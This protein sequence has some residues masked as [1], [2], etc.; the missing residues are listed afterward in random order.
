MSPKASKPDAP[1][2]A[3]ARV[4]PELFAF[5]AFRLDLRASQ[6]FHGTT[7][8]P[9]RPKTWAVLVYLAARAGM[10]VSKDDL[11]GAVWPDVAVTPDTLNKSIGEL[12]SALGD[13]SRTPRF[14]ET[15]HRRGFR[16]I[17]P[18]TQE[19][20]R[21]PPPIEIASG[22]QPSA[23]DLR[24]TTSECFVGR[25]AE[26]RHLTDRFAAAHA[27]DRQVVFVTGPAGVG[28]TAL[29][30]AF[31]ASRAVG[32][33]GLPV[34]IG[35]AGCI[36]QH[37]PQ[38]PYMPVLEALQRLVRPPN[39]ERMIALMRRAAP[40]WLAQ[41]PWLLGDAEE[42]ALRQSLL[43]VRP[44]RMPREL[45]VLLDALTAELTLVLVLEDL[46]WSDPATVDLLTLLAQ[47][48]DPARLMIV[49]TY[50]Q[51][52]V[53]VSEHVLA[54]AVRALQVQGRCHQLALQDLSEQ[55]VAD[56]L[57]RRFPHHSFPAAL[58]H[59]LHTHTGGQP[60]FLV[61][62]LD[63]LVSS[64]CILDTAPGWALSV[65]LAHIDLGVPDDVRRLIQGQFRS[66]SPIERSV[67]EAA[68]VASEEITA[69]ILAA[70]L[71]CDVGVVEQHCE[72]LAHAQRFLQVDGTV[73]WPSGGRAQRYAFSHE[74]RRHIVYHE[75]PAGRRMRLHGAI[76]RALEAAYG[77]GADGIAAALAGHFTRGRDDARALHY[78]TIAGV[79]A[80]QRFASREAVEYLQRA[81]ALVAS[82]ADADDG[83]RRETEVRLALGRALGEVHGF[84][85][86][87]IRENYARVS[88]L[89]AET[90]NAAQAFEA[91]Y[92]RWYLHVMRAERDM[93]LALAAELAELAA[94]L[95]TPGHGVLADSVL[96][97]TAF[98]DA[99]F[100]DA[101][102]HMASL[103]AR[104]SRHPDVAVPIA[105]GVDPLIAASGHCAG[106][107]WFLG[108]SERARDM[109]QRAVGRARES[110]NPFFLAAALT[111]ASLLHLMMREFAAADTLGAEAVALSA[112]QGFA[113]WHTIAAALQ[114]RTH[115][116][117]NK[118]R[119]SGRDIETALQHLQSTGTLLLTPYFHVFLAETLLQASA[120]TAGLAAVDGG[121]RIAATSLDRAYVPEL[122]RLKGELLL[123]PSARRSGPRAT[124]SR[125]AAPEAQWREAEQCLLRAAELSRAMQAKWLE[126]RA[127]TSLARAWHSHGRTQQARQALSK[128]IASFGAD[129]R[130]ADLLDARAQL[131]ELARAG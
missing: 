90:R 119:Q 79:R 2:P 38:E 44:E 7:A 39:V 86:E 126:L 92:V 121:L 89:C 107:L 105:Y 18:V 120:R 46:H 83:Q 125:A 47:R 31:L 109:A 63:Q 112:A 55:D 20:D 100:A 65:P 67:L 131:G 29:I 108:E 101:V 127:A 77:T 60:L 56:Y 4:K 32:E 115:A 116:E 69:P 66:L 23:R 97:R 68:S 75:T 104:L 93:T 43:G 36:E 28:K 62:L 57:T 14:L 80:H 73:E 54:Q 113:M 70:A 45:A 41:M 85:A 74:L 61:A 72:T 49:G 42:A 117:H 88:V 5:G 78:L 19:A 84:A 35:R 64:G 128:A 1:D 26:L 9:L 10:L 87:S 13:D 122:W 71:Q 82:V 12:R 91:L 123:A 27:G 58:A 114:A 106:A 95:A 16:F 96:V 50:R 22:W 99:R 76:G 25:D 15:V 30:D 37:G 8:I 81:L 24:A 51:A 40:L 17:A 102:R 110:G 6:L 48:R 59:H 124:R 130:A 98:Y 52:D 33:H 21:S 34:W 53:A 3:A 111:Q 11:L 94:H 118:G 129:S 103:D